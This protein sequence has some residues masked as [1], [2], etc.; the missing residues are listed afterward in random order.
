MILFMFVSY[1]DDM[2]EEAPSSSIFEDYSLE[3][4]NG[5]EP[6][7]NARSAIVMDFDSGRVLYQKNAFIK[8]P[9]AST[10]KVMTAIV[11][12]EKR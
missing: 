6:E 7:I 3:V 10:T 8:R 12:L 11:A 2:I 4:F 9:M 5:K 1:A